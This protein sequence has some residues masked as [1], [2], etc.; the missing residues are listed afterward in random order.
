MLYPGN[1]QQL[2]PGGVNALG[3]HVPA[4]VALAAV[5]QA[6]VADV[7]SIGEQ[8][9]A[10]QERMEG[11]RHEEAAEQRLIV[12]VATMRTQQQQQQGCAGPRLKA[13]TAVSRSGSLCPLMPW[14]VVL[15][16]AACCI[17]LR[18]ASRRG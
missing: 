18:L 14:L 10:L 7:S 13:D 11:V 12:Q 6:R 3:A 9:A 5:L 16:G 4:A 17:C 2:L 15:V 8:Q 1:L